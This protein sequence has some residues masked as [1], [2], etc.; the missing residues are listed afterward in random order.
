MSNGEERGERTSGRKMMEKKK[1]REKRRE[2]RDNS[3]SGALFR[4]KF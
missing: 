4:Y 3:E 1:K 2:I